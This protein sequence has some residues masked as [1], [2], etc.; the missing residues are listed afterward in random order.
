MIVGLTGHVLSV[1]EDH[2][3][4]FVN[5]IHYAIEMHLRDLS[6]LTQKVESSL[7]I[8]PIY[9]EDDQILFGFLATRERDVFKRLIKISGVDAWLKIT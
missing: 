7:H 4:M 1:H 9:R 6:Q 3:V 2:C 8:A 5:G